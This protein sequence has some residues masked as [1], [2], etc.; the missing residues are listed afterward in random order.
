M[1]EPGEIVLERLAELPAGSRLL[2]ALEGVEGL[3]L[4]GG[5]V[6]DLL[7]GT[8]PPRDLDLVSEHDG[9]AVAEALAAALGGRV[10]VHGRFG[11]ASV[12]AASINVA[13]ARAESYPRPG[14]LPEVRPGSLGDDMARRDFTVNAVAVGLSADVRGVVHHDA[15]SFDDLDARVLRVLHDASFA[16]DPTRLVRLARYAARLGFE[17]EEGTARLAREAFA[18]GA[19]ETAGRARMGHEL[20]LLLREP[21][22]IRAVSVLRSLAGEASLDPGLDIDEPLL[23]RV[24]ALLPADHLALLAALTR[25]VPADR[26]RPWLE[27]AHVI[28]AGV[29]L[30]A[31]EDPEGLAR[32]MG[33]AARPSDLWRLLRRRP[34]QAVALA[35][36]LGSEDAARRWL[37]ELR[38]V[39][40][41]I[42]GDDLMRE[43]I[44]QGPEIGARLEAALV[45]KLDEGLAS[46]EEELAAALEA[47]V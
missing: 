47:R 24:A 32:A 40:L 11:T 17:V 44:A 36:A 31:V 30:D 16:D 5:A 3:H 19:P 28:D 4:V 6:R 45:R 26:L 35:G 12:E 21:A 33:E 1:D 14:A 13:T 41:E 46:R 34:P 39:R 2:A 18:T 25:R 10:V 43:G 7:L 38:H 37:D 20:V 27:D 42:G 29:V 9:A 23:E 15:R 22:P 8:G